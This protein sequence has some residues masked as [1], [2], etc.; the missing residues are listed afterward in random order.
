MSHKQAARTKPRC[1]ISSRFFL[2][3]VCFLKKRSLILKLFKQNT[4]MIYKL[5]SRLSIN[6]QLHFVPLPTR[7][8]VTPRAAP[9]DPECSRAQAID[10]GAQHQP[11]ALPLGS[12]H[13]SKYA[14]YWCSAF[15]ISFQN[16]QCWNPQDKTSADTHPLLQPVQGS[17]CQW[18]MLPGCSS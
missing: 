3:F 2:L 11:L 6:L 13:F 17:L 4:I 1:Y 10:L 18:A 5:E 15:L 16:S 7:V 12:T 14:S 9:F 8:Q